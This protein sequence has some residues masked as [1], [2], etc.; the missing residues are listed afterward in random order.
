MAEWFVAAATDVAAV[1][2]AVPFEVA[3][4]M[5]VPTLTA[6]QML[7]DVL[8]AG[9]GATLLVNGA[10]SVTGTLTVQLAAHLGAEVIATAGSRGPRARSGQE[11]RPARHDHLRPA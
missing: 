5:P 9:P 3:A 8:G 6:D 2:D 10:G 11:R 1:P 7:C 4:A